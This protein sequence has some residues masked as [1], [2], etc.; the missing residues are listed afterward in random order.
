M[1][2]IIASAP[3]RGAYCI[4]FKIFLCSHPAHTDLCNVWCEQLRSPA[5]N[6]LYATCWRRAQRQE[7]LGDFQQ[8]TRGSMARICRWPH[9]IHTNGP[10]SAGK[11]GW[12][13]QER[14]IR[15]HFCELGLA[16]P[17]HGSALSDRSWYHSRDMA[18]TTS[19]FPP[20]PEI[21]P[22][23]RLRQRQARWFFSGCWTWSRNVLA[24]LTK[25][26]CWPVMG[27]VERAS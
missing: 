14:Q 13:A 23:K 22:R 9:Y 27:A 1:Q 25:Q 11:S 7:K 2:T 26:S 12:K 17:E 21:I 19:A 5:E 15:S 8:Y 4:L 16:L 18:W 20:F 3:V 24:E 10:D 6:I